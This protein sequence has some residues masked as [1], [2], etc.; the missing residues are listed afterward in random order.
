M[1]RV[2]FQRVA[3]R[4]VHHAVLEFESPDTPVDFSLEHDVLVLI[5]ELLVEIVDLR[6]E[7]YFI[8]RFGCQI[9]NRLSP[10]SGGT[11]PKN[12]KALVP[13]VLDVLK[14]R[15]LPDVVPEKSLCEK[16]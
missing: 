1:P 4:H 3:H 6:I 13:A 11:C 9:V 7:R 5:V 2:A 16:L 14:I 10:A 12:E 8:R 15:P